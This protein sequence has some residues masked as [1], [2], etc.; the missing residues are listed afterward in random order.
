MI[1]TKE[2]PIHLVY[3]AGR[4]VKKSR[5]L[6]QTSWVIGSGRIGE[7]SVE[8]LIQGLLG[9]LA[10]ADEWKMVSAGRE[11]LDVRM[12]G[13]G[14]P[15]VMECRNCHAP[16]FP[17]ERIEKEPELAPKY[18]EGKVDLVDLCVTN[19]EALLLLQEGESAAFGDSA[20]RVEIPSFSLPNP[21]R[22]FF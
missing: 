20:V 9:A 13:T 22:F 4:Y 16:T 5:E 11:D 21:L 7:G 18:L 15:F 8:E 6:S 3:V 17:L 10:P 1:L 2:T 14:R 12:L 19:K